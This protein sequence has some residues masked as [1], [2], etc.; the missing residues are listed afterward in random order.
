MPKYLANA[1]TISANNYDE[2]VQRCIGG[3][4][5]HSS[6]LMHGHKN[7]VVIDAR[8]WA[9]NEVAALGAIF[10]H[11]KVTFSY[12]DESGDTANYPYTI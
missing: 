11:F 9:S 12:C 1:K 2:D 3:L 6:K 7:D 10:H 4:Y 5:H 8:D